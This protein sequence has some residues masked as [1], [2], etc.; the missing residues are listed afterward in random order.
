MD[1]ERNIKNFLHETTPTNL[2]E[3]VLPFK[4]FFTMTYNYGRG[5]SHT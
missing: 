3:H 5:E 1:D 4:H 2:F